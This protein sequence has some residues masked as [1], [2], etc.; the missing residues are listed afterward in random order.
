VSQDYQHALEAAR[1]LIDGHAPLVPR[2]AMLRAATEMV[3]TRRRRRHAVVVGLAAVVV[4]AVIA[5]LWAHPIAPGVCEWVSHASIVRFGLVHVL[6]FVIAAGLAGRPDPWAQL[7][8]R[9]VWWSSL[10]TGSAAMVLEPGI[11]P[12]LLPTM[13]F[14]AAACLLVVGDEDLA[15]PVPGGGFPLAAHRG[16]IMLLMILAMADTETL[17]MAALNHDSP[18]EA[19]Y[20]V[21]DLACAIG[22]ALAMWGLYRLRVWGL[23]ATL[24]LDVVIAGLGVGGLLFY[25]WEFALLLSTT[26][27]LQLGLALPLLRTLLRKEP[28]DGRP[29]VAG[30]PRWSRWIL[31]GFLVFD[32]WA[33]ATMSDAER[34]AEYCAGD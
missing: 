28:P 30:G 13:T 33:C 1:R 4:L 11:L 18:L 8:V 15:R 26:A 14:A 16:S 3:A 2:V 29:A 5:S 17:A 27:L 22:M 23:V 6:G 9:A 10:S 25:D 34:V 12:L 19:P 32:G 24:V 21:V 7:L 31:A 20:A